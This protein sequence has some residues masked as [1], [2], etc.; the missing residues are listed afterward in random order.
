M[1]IKTFFT[2]DNYCV[3]PLSCDFNI[4]QCSFAL[5]G[6]WIDW[7]KLKTMEYQIE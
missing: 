5:Q 6:T 7:S 4:K 3:V 2:G 1:V